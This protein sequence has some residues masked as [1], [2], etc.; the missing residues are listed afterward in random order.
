MK[1]QIYVNNKKVYSSNKISKVNAEIVI[2]RVKKQ[3]QCEK[4]ED[5]V[6]KGFNVFKSN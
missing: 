3:F 2:N 5:A 6:K 4:L 1:L